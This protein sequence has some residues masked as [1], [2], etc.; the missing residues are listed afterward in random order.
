M[1]E[2]SDSNE[3]LYTVIKTSIHKASIEAAAVTSISPLGQV[4]YPHHLTLNVIVEATL[5]LNVPIE[6]CEVLP[7]PDHMVRLGVRIKHARVFLAPCEGLVN[8]LMTVLV[9]VLSEYARDGR[10]CFEKVEE[11]ACLPGSKDY[12]SVELQVSPLDEKTRSRFASGKPIAYLKCAQ[13][14]MTFSGSTLSNLETHLAASPL[15]R[16]L[17]ISLK[18]VTEQ[19]LARGFLKRWPFVFNRIWR[20]KIVKAWP[21]Q[22]S[23]S[24]SLFQLASRSRNPSLLARLCGLRETSDTRPLVE[25]VSQKLFNLH[26]SLERPIITI[27]QARRSPELDFSDLGQSEEAEE[28]DS[29]AIQIQ[30][31]STHDD[32]V[33]ELD[34]EIEEILDYSSQGSKSSCSMVSSSLSLLDQHFSDNEYDNSLFN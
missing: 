4:P 22:D 34:S 8:P 33:L 19:M 13:L 25:V 5:P 18:R 28:E 12:S 16:P 21:I 6:A 27:P 24:D 32:K 2:S 31:D 14:L 29:K 11:K 17:A 3:V 1:T 7:A 30:T 26:K 15:G 20:E 23:I 10:A 9:G